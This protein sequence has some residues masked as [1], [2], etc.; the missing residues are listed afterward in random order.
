MSFKEITSADN[1]L[2]KKVSKLKNKKYREEF[3]EFMAEGRLSL[4]AGISSAYE[5]SFVLASKSFARLSV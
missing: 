3:G 4:E 5:L 2:I 1:A